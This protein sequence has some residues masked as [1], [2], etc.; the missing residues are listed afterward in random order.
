VG[1]VVHYAMGVTSSPMTARCSA[2]AA[3]EIGSPANLI[4]SFRSATGRFSSRSTRRRKSSSA[5]QTHI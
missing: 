1:V 3:L 5:A 2:L 4:S